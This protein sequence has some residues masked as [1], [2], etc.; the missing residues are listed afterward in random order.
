M[1]TY[2]FRQFL[3]LDTRTCN[4]SYKVTSAQHVSE[5][6][7]VSLGKAE[8][9]VVGGGGLIG[10]AHSMLDILTRKFI[11]LMDDDH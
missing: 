9:S 2:C 3:P 4:C 11:S 7:L 8:R 6:V 5:G 1:K 10:W